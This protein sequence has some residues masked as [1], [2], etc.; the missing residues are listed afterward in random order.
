MREGNLAAGVAAALEK[1]GISGDQLELEI[2]EN[3]ILHDEE[4]TRRTFDEIRDLGVSIALDRFGTGYSSLTHLRR[5]P[6]DRLKIDRSIVRQ[7]ETDPSKAAIV[8]GIIGLARQLSI[9]VVAE[10][11]E[12]EDE[13]RLLRAKG[14]ED[15]QG[16]LFS[17][18]LPPDQVTRFFER[19]KSED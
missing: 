1:A 16:Y 11:V 9:G 14:C 10:G 3:S 5:F 8:G 18:P 15:M 2:K 17:K 6:I 13:L 12:N 19:D 4:H 7:M